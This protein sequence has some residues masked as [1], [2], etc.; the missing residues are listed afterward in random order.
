MKKEGRPEHAEAFAAGY[1]K[2]RLRGACTALNEV[3]QNES[4]KE[5]VSPWEIAIN[6]ALMGD[7]D[8]TF[9]W[10]EKAYSERSGRMAYV[11]ID[12]FLEP[13]HSDRRYIDLLKRMGLPQ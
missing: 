6:Y 7:R 4:Q 13:F 10:L 11:K 8:H 9:A 12:D 2:A 3:L 1:K 5:Y